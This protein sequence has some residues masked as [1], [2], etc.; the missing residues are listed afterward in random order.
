MRKALVA[1]LEVNGYFPDGQHGFRSLRSTLTQLLSFWDSILEKLED[2]AGVDVIYT[3][4]SKAFDKVERGVL[5]HKIRECKVTAKVGCWLASFLDPACRQQAVVVE[6]AVSDL[7]PVI[8]GVPQ[9]TVLGPVLFLIHIRDIADGLSP[10]TTATSFADDTRVQR[11]VR[12]G[13]DC[14]DLQDDL[15][16]IYS[17][18]ESVNMHFN[19]DKFECL[20]F[21]PGTGTLPSYQY[22]GPDNS[23]IEVKDNLKDLGVQISSALSFKAHIEKTVA[24][25]TKLVGWS[26]RSFRRRSKGIMRVIWQTLIQPKIDYC[27]QLWSPGDQESINKIES[28]QRH[29]TSK[30]TGLEGMSYWER[31][32]VMQLYS[33]ER[34]RERYML[35]FLWKISQG[36]VGGYDVRFS[37]SPRRGRLIIPN[38]IVSSAPALVRRA[39]EA[40]LSVKGAKIF[41]LLPAYIRNIDSENVDTFKR[42]LDLFLSLVPDQPSIPG[43]PRVAE[44][45]SLLHQVPVVQL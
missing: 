41:N 2:G 13:Q 36:M 23:S 44:T 35:I 18:A 43:H 29:F 16:A 31:L 26:L 21:W 12:S 15:Q 11:A 17:W 32:Q 10:G 33:Q 34:R 14:A 40:S 42:E 9:G 25:S 19:S 28:V 39:R 6:G 38:Q 45:N 4:F 8:S 1:H 24:A 37:Y 20:R 30:V 3:D 27:S 7:S 22:R 5:L